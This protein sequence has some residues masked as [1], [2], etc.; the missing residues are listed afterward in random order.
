MRLH[1]FDD[2]PFHQHPAPFGLP[3]TTDAKFNDGYWFAFYAAGWYFV[4]AAGGRR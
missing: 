2:Y 4:A 1:S 3:A